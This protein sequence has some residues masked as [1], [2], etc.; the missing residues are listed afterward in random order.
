MKQEWKKKRQDDNAAMR[1]QWSAGEEEVFSPRNFRRKAHQ[2]HTKKKWRD[3]FLPAGFERTQHYSLVAWSCGKRLHT[4]PAKT[5]WFLTPSQLI[6]CLFFWHTWHVCRKVS[7]TSV[8]RFNHVCAWGTE[9]MARTN[10]VAHV[11]NISCVSATSWTP[12][13]PS[14]I[15]KNPIHDFEMCPLRFS[16][17]LKGETCLE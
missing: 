13:Q 3:V 9:K 10:A 14:E 7:M 4:I 2:K 16:T 17:E 1:Q 12:S 8:L 6:K 5:Q 11:T 15:N